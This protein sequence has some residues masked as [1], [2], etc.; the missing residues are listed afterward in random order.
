MSST[1]LSRP[2]SRGTVPTREAG[3]DNEVPRDNK[4]RPRIV[5]DCDGCDGSGR[6]PSEKKPAPATVKCKRSCGP[7]TKDPWIPEGKRVKAYTRTTTFID[8]IEDKSNL[9]A[10]GKRMVLVGAALDPTL[11]DGAV[12]EFAT[13]NAEGEA[14]DEERAKAAKDWLNRR[15]ESAATRA[16]ASEKADRGTYLHGLS[17]L[18]DEGKDLPEDANFEAVIDMDSYKRATTGFKI[19]HMERLVVLDEFSVA[20]TPDRVS[21]WAGAEP[22][23]APDGHVFGED[24]LIITD[25]KTGTVDYGA[26]KMA[27]QLAIYAHSKLYDMKTGERESLG[28]INLQWGIIMN[29]PA[30]SGETTLY[31]ADLTMGWAAV[32]VAREIRQLRTQGK[33]ALTQFRAG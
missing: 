33:G 31:W 2:T 7:T 25:L 3:G 17:E 9:M 18:V 23:V 16:G 24:E 12:D 29:T 5:I 11:L 6:I 20:G 13:I 27:M 8:V 32:R 26:L 14:Y 19:R 22:L 28:N 21:T 4:G 10:W 15:A 30:N 1:T